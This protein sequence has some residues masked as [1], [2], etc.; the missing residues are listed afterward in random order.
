MACMLFVTD[1]EATSIGNGALGRDDIPC[2]P[3]NR[4]NCKEGPPANNYQRGC[5][6]SERCRGGKKKGKSSQDTEATSIGNGALGRDDIPCGP[7]N[8]ENCK[9]G[10]PANNYQRGCERS[11]RCRG[12]K[13]KGKSSQVDFRNVYAVRTRVV[14]SSDDLRLQDD[15]YQ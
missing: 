4:E 10:P 11:E 15:L 1:T 3:N 2:G 13:K 6:R 12:G 14:P 5:E 8:R 7:N 9:E